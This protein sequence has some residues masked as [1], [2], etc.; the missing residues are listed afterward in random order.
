MTAYLSRFLRIGVGKIFRCKLCFGLS[1]K[2]LPVIKCYNNASFR[3]FSG[4]DKDRNTIAKRRYTKCMNRYTTKI[5]L[6]AAY[7]I[8]NPTST[9]MFRRAVS[10]FLATFQITKKFQQQLRR[11]QPHHAV[12]TQG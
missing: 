10:A 3:R 9:V 4:L 8:F 1:F 2:A 11:R 12:C 7:D 6:S 5:L